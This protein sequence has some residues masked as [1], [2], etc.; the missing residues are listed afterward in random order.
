MS[1]FPVLIKSDGLNE[2]RCEVTTLTACNLD[3][4]F[5][6]ND[7]QICQIQLAPVPLDVE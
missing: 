1:D 2:M 5:F 4:R 3:T 6:P 7:V